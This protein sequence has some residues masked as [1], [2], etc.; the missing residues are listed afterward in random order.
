M[1]QKV[2]SGEGMVVQLLHDF[3]IASERHVDVVSSRNQLHR[4]DLHALDHLTRAS[5]KNR[6]LT[7]SMLGRKL[8]LTPAATTALIDR[9]Q[10]AGYAQRH[11]DPHDRRVIQVAITA[12]AQRECAAMFAPLVE[13]LGA[14]VAEFSETEQEIL[15]RFL[16]ATIAAI[17]DVDD[18]PPSGTDADRAD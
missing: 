12:K 10:A 5:F 18:A 4:T 17:H 3:A 16:S 15:V 8:G 2:N 13:R 9:L 7:A 14:T 11:R 1:G 6:P